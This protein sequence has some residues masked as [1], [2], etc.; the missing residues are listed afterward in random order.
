SG[1][2]CSMTSA[3][4]RIERSCWSQSG[5][6][7]GRPVS[8]HSGS[9]SLG[10]GGGAEVVAGDG[11]TT[12]FLSVSWFAPQPARRRKQV[13]T[14]GLSVPRSTPPALP[15]ASEDSVLGAVGQ[16]R[17]R[18][19]RSVVTPGAELVHEARSVPVEARRRHDQPRRDSGQ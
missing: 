4:A 11:R 10:F 16:L 14:L 19:Q 13:D 12:N 9:G 1:S 8:R 15:S 3:N 5:T 18:D 7:I 2:R 17:T 6:S